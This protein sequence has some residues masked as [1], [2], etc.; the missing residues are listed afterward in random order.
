MML[1]NFL[2]LVPEKNKQNDATNSME[3]VRI[4]SH[5]SKDCAIVSLYTYHFDSFN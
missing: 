3:K 4:F 2:R 5:Q 1:F